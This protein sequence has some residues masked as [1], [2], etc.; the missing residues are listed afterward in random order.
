MMLTGTA[1]Q[2]NGFAPRLQTLHGEQSWNQDCDHGT[3]DVHRFNR[4][5]STL[6]ATPRVD[7]QSGDP[8]SEI[9]ETHGSQLRLPGWCY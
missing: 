1:H 7:L 2:T 3:C 5:C 6:N 8:Q 9:S 4:F